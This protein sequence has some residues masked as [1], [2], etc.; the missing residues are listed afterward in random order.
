MYGMGEGPDQSRRHH[1]VLWLQNA[2]NTSSTELR[3]NHLT[4][5]DFVPDLHSAGDLELEGQL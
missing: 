5:G 1:S 4:P 2:M 3:F